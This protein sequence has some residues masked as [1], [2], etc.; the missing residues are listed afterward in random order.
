VEEEEEEEEESD[1]DGVRHM[2]SYMLR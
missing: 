2:A 1:Q